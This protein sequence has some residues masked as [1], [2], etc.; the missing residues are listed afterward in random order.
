MDFTKLKA[1]YEIMYLSQTYMFTSG[2]LCFFVIF[3]FQMA[4]V[5]RFNMNQEEDTNGQKSM[6]ERSDHNQDEDS[7]NILDAAKENDTSPK[8]KTEDHRGV[9]SNKSLV[10]VSLH[11]QQKYQNKNPVFFSD[12]SRPR[13]RPPCHN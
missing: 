11:L 6:V 9:I 8:E 2:D 12:Y 3:I 7:V 5:V 4:K 10:S 1:I 13:T